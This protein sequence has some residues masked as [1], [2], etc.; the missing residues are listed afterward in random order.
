MKEI[1]LLDMEIH[2]YKEDYTTFIG[3][4]YIKKGECEDE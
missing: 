1:Y 4:Y 2:A 3:Y